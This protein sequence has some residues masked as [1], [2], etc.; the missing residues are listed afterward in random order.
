MTKPWKLKVI[1]INVNGVKSLM[2][3]KLGELHKAQYDVIM[4][5]ETKLKDADVNDDLIYRWK[6]LSEGEAYSNPAASSQ[7]GGVAVLL[8]AHA[9]NTLSNREHIPTNNKNHRHII[10]KATLQSHM[11]YIHSI[12]APVRRGERPG[13]FNNLTTPPSPEKHIIGVTLIVYSIPNSTPMA[14]KE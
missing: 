4:L 3:S 14:T 7:A 10:I 11:I 8:S 1:S 13:F 5:Q 12:Y 2:W 6:Q 9:C